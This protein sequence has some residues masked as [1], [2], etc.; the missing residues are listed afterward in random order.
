M[1]SREPQRARAASRPRSLRLAAK[2]WS[3]FGRGREPAAHG[4][5]SNS[6]RQHKLQQV[7]RPARFRAD[8]GHLEAAERLA[9][10][11]G[12]GDLAVDI[13]IADAEVALDAADVGGAA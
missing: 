8:A 2:R 6:P 12:A 1:F 13:E 11:Q 9:L 10:D 7:I 3:T 4:I 5:F